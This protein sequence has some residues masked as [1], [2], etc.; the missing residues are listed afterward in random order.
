M[1]SNLLDVMFRICPEDVGHHYAPMAHRIYG[2]DVRVVQ[3]VLPDRQGRLPGDTGY[4]QKFMSWQHE[5]WIKTPI[6]GTLVL[7]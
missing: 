4:D 1:A 5:L 7:Q 2:A 6:Q 3:V